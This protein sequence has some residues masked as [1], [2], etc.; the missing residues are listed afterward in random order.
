LWIT[1]AYRD[2]DIIPRRE[3]GAIKVDERCGSDLEVLID[4]LQYDCYVEDRVTSGAGGTKEETADSSRKQDTVMRL[5]GPRHSIFERVLVKNNTAPEV[6]DLRHDEAVKLGV[7]LNGKDLSRAVQP[8]DATARAA[9]ETG[10]VLG[11]LEN[12]V[13]MHLVKF[14][15]A[16]ILDQPC[17]GKAV[18]IN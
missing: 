7:R 10:E 6:E 13:A 11:N 15:S 18:R 17:W 12:C 2:S 1:R 9:A 14:L 3:I 16:E 8:L 4:C 5:L